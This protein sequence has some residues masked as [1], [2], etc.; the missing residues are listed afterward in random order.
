MLLIGANCIHFNVVVS[1]WQLSIFSLEMKPQ[2]ITCPCFISAL[3]IHEYYCSYPYEIGNLRKKTTL[4][5]LALSHHVRRQCIIVYPIPKEKLYLFELQV[6]DMDFCF[7]L[8]G[9]DQVM[10]GVGIEERW[11]VLIIA[12]LLLDFDWRSFRPNRTTIT[13]IILLIL[14][15]DED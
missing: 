4:H 1:Y 10:N 7:Y 14:T 5:T 11:F 9:V 13:I 15:S 8:W 2:Y 3:F 6:Y 12:L